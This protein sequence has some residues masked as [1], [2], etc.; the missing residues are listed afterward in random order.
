MF[1]RI[2]NRALTG[3]KV[4]LLVR[5]LS[6]RFRVQGHLQGAELGDVKG[7]QGEAFGVSG[8]RALGL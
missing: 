7:F 8:F 6:L 4:S 5:A 1:S 3:F 2:L